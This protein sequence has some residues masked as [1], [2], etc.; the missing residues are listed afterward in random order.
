M[1]GKMHKLL[2]KTTGFEFFGDRIP[3]LP[4]QTFMV[5]DVT[6]Y[7]RTHSLT[8]APRQRQERSRHNGLGQCGDELTGCERESQGSVRV[9]KE[10]T[11]SSIHRCSE[12][13]K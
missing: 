11:S 6:E 1:Q 7:D 2:I 9:E 3:D 4:P 12:E 10:Y 5:T 8:C 13:V